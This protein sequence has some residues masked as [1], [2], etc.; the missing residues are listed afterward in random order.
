M[1]RSSGFAR[2]AWRWTVADKSGVTYWR[3][4]RDAAAAQ[5]MAELLDWPG[6]TPRVETDAPATVGVNLNIGADNAGPLLTLDLNNCD[7]AVETDTLRAAPAVTTTIHLPDAWRGHE[8]QASCVTPEMKDGAEPVLLA[9]DAAIVDPQHGTLRLRT[10]AF[11]TCL[12]V[13]LRSPAGQRG[14]AVR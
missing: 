4:D 2:C 1:R 10:P 6:R 3:K 9:G 7:L 8:V 14:A 12:I 5:R 13:F 11:D